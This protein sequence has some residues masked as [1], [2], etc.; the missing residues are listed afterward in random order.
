MTSTGT[1]VGGSSNADGL[2][3]QAPTAVAGTP[4]TGKATITL[5]VPSWLQGDYDNNGAY[6]DPKGVASF[7]I[8]RGHLWVV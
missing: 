7:G 3:L 8:W 2:L 4:D 6:E 5:T 1:L